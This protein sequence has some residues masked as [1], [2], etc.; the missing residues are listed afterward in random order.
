MASDPDSPPAPGDPRTPAQRERAQRFESLGLLAGGAAH[1]VNNVLGVI[2]GYVELARMGL[3]EEHP[4]VRRQLEMALKTVE[5]ARELAD[6]LLEA[7]RR[8]ARRPDVVEPGPVVR[9]ACDLLGRTLDA[10][11]AIAVDVADDAPCTPLDAEA[12]QQVVVNLVRNAAQAMPEGGRIHVTVARLASDGADGLPAGLWTHLTVA[13]AGPG[14]PADIADRIFEP[15]VTTRPGTRSGLGLAV[16]R[17]LVERFGGRID[18]A[19]DADGATLRVW[20]PNALAVRPAPPAAA[21]D[22]ILVVDADPA[23]REVLRTYLERDGHVVHEAASAAEAESCLATE[24]DAV[25]VVMV[26]AA[27]PDARGVD[28]AWKAAGTA[29]ARRIV[30]V[31]GR[32]GVAADAALPSGAVILAK[33]FLHDDLTRALRG[34]APG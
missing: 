26:D 21:G 22:A 6:G 7:A 15:G 16:S 9:A 14:V 18:A 19:S 12:L 3:G 28:L 30:F 32:P 29:P 34:I 17:A 1:D 27:L 11:I 31:T 2:L 5:R 10:R 33:P 13:D 4:T 25:G 23:A 8:E 24:T 20:L